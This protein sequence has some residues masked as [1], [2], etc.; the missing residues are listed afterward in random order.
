MKGKESTELLS[1]TKIFIKQIRTQHYRHRFTEGGSF[2]LAQT[3][4][5]KHKNALV[6]NK[7]IIFVNI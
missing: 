4:L 5:L 2:L 7:D 6:L 1:Q 3:C